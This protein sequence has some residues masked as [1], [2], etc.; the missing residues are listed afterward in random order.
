MFVLLKT[1]IFNIYLFVFHETSVN[2]NVFQMLEI[3]EDDLKLHLSKAKDNA[4]H[5]SWDIKLS[6]CFIIR[7]VF[8]MYETTLFASTEII[9]F[10]F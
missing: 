9:F 8:Q 4:K 1:V 3:F 7:I 6:Q 5:Q 10:F 2:S